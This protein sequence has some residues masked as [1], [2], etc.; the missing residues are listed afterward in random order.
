MRNHGTLN[1][2]A[3]LDAAMEGALLLEWAC[4]LYWHAA[5]IGEPAVL[6]EE[7]LADVAAQVGRLNYG[8]VSA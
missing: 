8:G 3:S 6:S 7:Q 4:S 5:Q 1:C 2:S